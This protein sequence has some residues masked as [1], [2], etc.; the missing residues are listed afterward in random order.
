MQ[1]KLNYNWLGRL[2]RLA[3]WPDSF[4]EQRALAFLADAI[5]GNGKVTIETD[6]RRMVVQFSDAVEKS[7]EEHSEEYGE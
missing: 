4:E 1:A 3:V 2:R 7:H 5:S 6:E